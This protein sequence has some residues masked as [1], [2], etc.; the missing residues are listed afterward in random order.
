MDSLTEF[1]KKK[2]LEVEPKTAEIWDTFGEAHK[3][4]L[5]V[6]YQKGYLKALQDI[7]WQVET[8]KQYGYEG[9]TKL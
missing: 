8:K 7:L 5:E 2:I 9:I 3:E 1:V 6:E 4:K